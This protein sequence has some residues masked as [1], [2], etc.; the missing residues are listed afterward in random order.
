MILDVSVASDRLRTWHVW[1]RDGE[2]A[3]AYSR[4]KAVS[5]LL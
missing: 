2:G 4:A 5:E 3:G 1:S